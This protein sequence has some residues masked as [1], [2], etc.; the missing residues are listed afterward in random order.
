MDSSRSSHHI[1]THLA[2]HSAASNA[3]MPEAAALVASRA[4][5]PSCPV[6]A[7]APA[8]HAV[9][10]CRTQASIAAPASVRPSQRPGRP[11]RRA[12]VRPRW[13]NRHDLAQPLRDGAHYED[14]PG[15]SRALPSP[16]GACDPPT[17]PAKAARGSRPGSPPWRPWKRVPVSPGAAA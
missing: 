4:E 6:G 5:G 13:R 15:T 14:L 10:T 17:T 1:V 16:F 12:P 3:M 7:G 11:A 9:T 8:S 2:N